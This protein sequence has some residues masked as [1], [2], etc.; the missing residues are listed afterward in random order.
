MCSEPHGDRRFAA[1]SSEYARAT[2]D[3]DTELPLSRIAVVV[4]PNRTR[5]QIALADAAFAFLSTSRNAR[6]KR[7]RVRKSNCRPGFE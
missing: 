6:H 4:E 7:P 5:A 1:A 2:D 3:S